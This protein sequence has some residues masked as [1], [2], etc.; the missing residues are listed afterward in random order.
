MTS[1]LVICDIACITRG[2]SDIL[3]YYFNRAAQNRNKTKWIWNWL[4]RGVGNSKFGCTRIPK[5]LYGLLR[6]S[7]GLKGFN[8]N[9]NADSEDSGGSKLVSWGLNYD[10][11]ILKKKI[12]G[13]LRYSGKKCTKIP[14]SCQPPDSKLKCV[15]SYLW[16]SAFLL[17][18]KLQYVYAK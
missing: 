1:N 5:I 11:N 14:G 16:W 4:I 2:I 9:F 3:A 6:V 13:I 18:Y 7:K 10:I 8:L 15:W 12:I 17:Y